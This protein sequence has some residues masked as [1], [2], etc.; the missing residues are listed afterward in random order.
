MGSSGGKGLK[1]K[2]QFVS[3][4][5]KKRNIPENLITFKNKIILLNL[6]LTFPFNLINFFECFFY[7]K[8]FIRL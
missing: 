5:G 4:D 1:H 2:V 3:E 7:V 6:I 8:H